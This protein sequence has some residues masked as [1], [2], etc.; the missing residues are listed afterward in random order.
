MQQA[1]QPP[2]F[3]QPLAQN[4]ASKADIPVTSPDDTRASQSLGFPPR[5]GQPP[6]AGGV[7]PQLPDM[8]GVLNLASRP[9]WWA[10]LGGRFGYDSTFATDPLINGYPQGATLPAGDGLGD[11]IST[12]ND[13]A[14]NPDTVGT[15]WVPGYSYGATAL[16][17]QTG[18]TVT[19]TPAQARKRVLTVAGTL[20][21]NLVLVVPNWRYDW[22]VYNNTG[23]AF[24]VTVRTAGGSGAV[25]AQNGAPTPVLCDGTNCVLSSPNI[26]PATTAGQAVQLGQAVGRLLDVKRFTASGTYTPTAGTR[27]IIVELVGGGGSGGGTIATTATQASVGAGGGAGAYMQFMLLTIPGSVAITVGAGGAGAAGTGAAGT[28]SVFGS[29]VT[30]GPGQG[31]VTRSEGS[32]T[33]ASMFL[34]SVVEG[35]PLNG[36]GGVAVIDDVPN[37]VLLKGMEGSAGTSGI[38]LAG[39]TF[40]RAGEGGGT[41]FG[42]TAHTGN[43]QATA[44]APANSGA[45]GAG[46]YATPSTPGVRNGGNGGSG[47]CLVWEYA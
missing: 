40:M 2:K 27:R 10:Q 25:V 29:Y 43:T 33:S 34:T 17:S 41:P 36:N 30:C 44:S 35:S 9:G 47:C 38:S 26:G 3:L 5:T 1:N 20:T 32:Q 39:G 22:T 7:P 12:A 8:N 45:G 11:W 18:G 46:I 42:S 14:V 37:V 19:L 4:D 16:A 21:S 15:G 13:N 6:E 23:G 31:G 28:A 24:S